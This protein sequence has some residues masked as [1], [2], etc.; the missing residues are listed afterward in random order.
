[1]PA[2]AAIAV[3]EAMN[4]FFIERSLA[5]SVRSHLP[6]SAGAG[7]ARRGVGPGRSFSDCAVLR[8]RPRPAL[9]R[10]RLI[11]VAV[12]YS[13]ARATG[14]HEKLATIRARRE[15]VRVDP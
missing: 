2:V 4:P 6:G 12:G 10:C 5:V 9:A 7:P 3:T 11:P 1:M 14:P 13:S 8:R 15:S